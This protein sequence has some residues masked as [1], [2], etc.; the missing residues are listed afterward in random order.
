MFHSWQN[1]SV[2]RKHPYEVDESFFAPFG[3]GMRG[4]NG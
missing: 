3:L 2:D 1:S 4:G